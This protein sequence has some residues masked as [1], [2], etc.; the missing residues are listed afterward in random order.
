MDKLDTGAAST[1]MILSM[2]FNWVDM[3]TH[4]CDYIPKNG[5]AVSQFGWL[6]HQRFSN[7]GGAICIPISNAA[8][9]TC[10]MS[11]SEYGIANL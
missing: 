5:I 2:I 11:L 9:S 3:Y 1:F 7:G 10:S 4:F 8:S 6:I